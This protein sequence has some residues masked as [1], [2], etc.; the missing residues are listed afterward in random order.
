MIYFHKGFIKYIKTN[1]I[2]FMKIHVEIAHPKLWAHREHIGS[3]KVV[4]LDHTQQ[5]GKKR[6]GPSSYVIT[7]FFCAKNPYNF[8][9]DAQYSY[10]K[11]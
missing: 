6:A 3:E 2:T 8:F 11:I 10:L 1:G 9:D 4:T 7:T 5:L